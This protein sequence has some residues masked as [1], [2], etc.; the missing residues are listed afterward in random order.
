MIN[1]QLLIQ[2]ALKHSV[3]GLFQDNQCLFEQSIVLDHRSDNTYVNDIQT[4]VKKQNIKYADIHELYL[5]H[6][7]G[8]FTG[9][10]AGVVIAKA[11]Y[12]LFQPRVHLVCSFDYLSACIRGASMPYGIVIAGSGKEG[13]FKLFNNEQEY[14]PCIMSYE[15]VASLSTKYPIYSDHR[16]HCESWGFSHVQTLAVLPMRSKQACSLNEIYPVYI[17]RED[18]LF[19]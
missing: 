3:L 16:Q 8:F 17:R 6:G 19:G 13:Y 18:E 4:M 9:V 5:V 12:Q 15:E 2:T 1:Y 11:W 10:R 14:S 7:P